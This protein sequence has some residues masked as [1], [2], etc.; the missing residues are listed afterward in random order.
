MNDSS[1]T[2]EERP[3]ATAGENDAS[4]DV[5]P[6]AAGVRVSGA[7]KAFHRMMWAVMGM[8][9]PMLTCREL[10]DF[11]SRYVEGALTQEERKAFERHLSMCRP[12]RA[13]VESYR[14]TIELERSAFAEPDAPVPDEVPEELVRAILTARRAAG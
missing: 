7:R 1:R 13:Y 3:G 6:A 8:F 4:T 10:T 2:P 9:G 11:L 5:A 12:C 14:K